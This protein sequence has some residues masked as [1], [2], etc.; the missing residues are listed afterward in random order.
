[1][2]FGTYMLIR[3]AITDYLLSQLKDA[4]NKMVCHDNCLSLGLATMD[5]QQIRLDEMFMNN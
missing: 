3:A 1:M 5:S 4:Q 2:C